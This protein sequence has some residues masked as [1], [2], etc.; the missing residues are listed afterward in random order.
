MQQV[1]AALE[2]PSLRAEAEGLRTTIEGRNARVWLRQLTGRQQPLGCLMLVQLLQDA[3]TAVP[4]S[5]T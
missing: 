3:V 4:E 5:H 1:L 2:Q